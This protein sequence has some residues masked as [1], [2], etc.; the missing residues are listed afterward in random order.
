M[1]SSGFR[2]FSL[3]LLVFLTFGCG[4]TAPED[5]TFADQVLRNGSVYTLDLARS[6]AQ[7]VA[8]DGSKLIYVG[9]DDG[10][11][12]WVGPN[13]EV[14][15]LE[16][17]MVLPGFFDSHSHAGMAV[18]RVVAVDLYGLTS[19]E[20][21]KT[22]VREFAE[23][24]SD[25]TAIRGM[26]WSN[27]L[28]P[29]SGPRKEDLDEIVPDRP[30]SLTSADAHSSW[31]NSKALETAGITKDTPNP[32]GGV[33]E[34]DAETG[35]PSGTLRESAANLISA[36]LPPYT[37]EERTEGL[38]SFQE[39]AAADG[40]TSVHIA[41]VGLDQAGM[42][43]DL[44]AIEAYKKLES[45]GWLSVR[46]R[47]S[48]E[49][50]PEMTVD[51]IAPLVQERA[52]HT[53]D[54]LQINSIKIFI[55][56]VVEGV[57]GYLSEPYAHRPDYYGELLWE[58]EHLNQVVA[59]LD[60]EGFQVHVHAIGDA[61]THVILNAFEHAQKVN[62]KRDSRHLITHLQLV[63][64]ED[65]PRFKELGVVG[66]PQPFWFMKGEFFEKIEVPYLGEERAG[67]EYPMQSLIEAGAVMASSSDFPV[68]I[69]FSPLIGIE[70]GM[71]RTEPGVSDPEQI[72]GPHERAS[73]EDMIAS[74]TVNGAYANFLEDVTG[75]LEVGK[76]ADLVVIDRNLFE[77]P[78]TEIGE[79]RVLLTL[80]EGK[81]V[82]RHPDFR[83]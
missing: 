51:D 25:K 64:P 55:D 72:L 73:L 45:R 79:S 18:V 35:E 43:A 47:G 58:P 8:I 17:K 59:A 61:A 68:T 50:T 80:L 29:P 27:S 15:D 21:Y 11:K 33:I 38:V 19:L 42:P 30:V 13:T 63:A 74:F 24:N 54:L 37:V 65:K 2:S 3:L 60:K 10:V 69:P 7:A 14:I 82:Y 39:M 44:G 78:E 48:F 22:A 77:I 62:G 67:S 71:T 31:V 40:I 36:V 28:F 41:T 56:G 23:K 81:E 6:W 46:F 66:L 49:F 75:S 53:G 5:E 12:A 76:M 20:E 83:W 70:Q 1:L 57:T 32:E 16:G 34:H 4:Q 9:S 26:G 52:R